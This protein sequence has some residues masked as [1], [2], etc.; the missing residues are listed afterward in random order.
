MSHLLIFPS[1]AGGASITVQGTIAAFAVLAIINRIATV[2]CSI[3]LYRNFGE[4]YAG[5]RRIFD[6]GRMRKFVPRSTP[7]GTPTGG[8]TV[9]VSERD[10]VG[11]R[12]SDVSVAVVARN[13]L[14][15]AG[16][17]SAAGLG[18][19]PLQRPVADLGDTVE[20]HPLPSA[21]QLQPGVHDGG[22]D[23]AASSP[24]RRQPPPNAFN[25]HQLVEDWSA[26]RAGMTG[27]PSL[28]QQ[29]SMS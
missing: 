21:R 9:Q 10:A 14:S 26:R 17:V 2:A 29:R 5:L 8:T 18:M 23:T 19:A 22:A 7:G 27:P 25:A 24:P 6:G 1:L 15:A 12:G 20:P 13:P 28:P 16:G 4:R 11:A 3:I